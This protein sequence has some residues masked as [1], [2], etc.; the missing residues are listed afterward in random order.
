MAFG[1][2]VNTIYRFDLAD[3]ILSLDADFLASGL[4]TVRYVRDFSKKRRIEHGKST[5]NRLYMVESTPSLTGAKADHRLALRPSQIEDFARAIAMKLAANTGR[6]ALQ[7]T[8]NTV[9]GLRPLT[10]DLQAN[11]GKSIVIAGR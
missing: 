9:N 7:F 5:M 2:P 4:G 10:R 11:R 8:P 3:R 1:Q 6:I